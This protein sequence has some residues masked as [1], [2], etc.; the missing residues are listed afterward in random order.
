MRR[1]R[2]SIGVFKV[3]R[4]Y[5]VNKATVR[6]RR[7]LFQLVTTWLWEDKLLK[8]QEKLSLESLTCWPYLFAVTQRQQLN[9]LKH[10]SY[11]LAVVK[12]FPDD[13]VV[14]I[15]IIII[16]AAWSSRQ[17]STFVAAYF[18]ALV[19]LHFARMTVMMK[20]LTMFNSYLYALIWICVIV[21]V[22]K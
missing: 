6:L 15:R 17:V 2:R 3:P 1:W 20:H 16:V 10:Q 5:A 21:L 11:T 18:H 22:C 19:C 9:N 7:H 8:A 13:H 14:T 4:A 12:T